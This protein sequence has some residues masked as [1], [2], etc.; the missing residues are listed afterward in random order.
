MARGQ[1]NKELLMMTVAISAAMGASAMAQAPDPT[2]VEEVVITGQRI[3]A[4]QSRATSIISAADIADRPLGAD[5]TQSL[6]KAPG[7]QISTGD[8]RGGSFSF[9]IYMRGLNKEQL[10]LTVDGVPSGDARFNGGSPPQR[11]IESSNI[12][13]ITVSQSSGDIGAP[14]RFALGGFIDFATDHPKPV[15]GGSVE[16]GY[17]SFDF[18]RGYMRFDTGEIAPGLAAYITYSQ[19]KNDI[20]TGRNSRK[21]KRDHVEFKMVQ[22]FADG[23]FLK[24][25]VSYND[26]Q[27][28]DFNI[29]TLPEFLSSPRSDRATDRLTGVPVTDLDFGGALGGE[30]TDVFGYLNGKLMIGETIEITANPYYQTLRGESYRYQ[31]RA[32]QLAGSNP[33]AVLS[34]N[35]NGGAVRPALTTLRSSNVLGGP[36][37]MRVTPRDRDRF[38]ITGEIKFSQLPLG[39]TVRVGG[40][41]E[42]GKSTEERRFYRLTDSLNSL[43]YNTSTINFVEYARTTKIETTMLYAQDSIELIAD[44]LQLDIGA[45]WF[46]IRYKAR[47]PL[48]Y[49]S[50]LDFSQDSGINPKLAFSWK[51]LPGVEVYGGYAQNFSGIP[52]DAFLG[53]TAVIAPGDLDPIRSENLDLG[54]RYVKGR[55]AFSAQAFSVHL[56][57]GIGI[58]P[59]DPTVVDVDEIIR[60]N[61]PTK[62]ANIQGLKNNGV[63]LTALAGAGPVDAFVSISFQDAKHEDPGAGSADRR[64]LAA[65]AVIGGAR[66]RDIPK[67]SAYG[68]ISYKPVQGLE[69]QGNVRY[70]GER[71]G[72]HIVAPTTFAEVG[73]ETI[74]SHT[75]FGMGVSYSLPVT[76]PLRGVKLQFNV[77]NMFDETYIG[78]VSSATANQPEFGLPG[79]TLDRYFIGAPRTYTVSLQARF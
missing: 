78:A 55:M 43:A 14:S 8:A 67:Q 77:D 39:Q 20:W 53:S 56:K 4:G 57:N 54:V 13:S 23:S 3:G 73:I 71:V 30:R 65:V 19:Q 68:E 31:D 33:Y 42:G 49:G 18:Y 24:A 44:V 69:V 5:I 79:R 6:V 26:Q 61:V 76:G 75:L 52:E 25:R 9:E 22:D 34:Y 27:D 16:A 58:V 74:P 7:V 47:S 21:S 66:V 70:V 10:G 32:R 45:T 37:D 59:R 11:F 62:A 35:A 60:G 28:N 41:V 1:R 64:N 63:E 15:M 38:G 12:G 50:V 2:A 72:G 17:G 40:W 46:D 51:A 29:V 48:E 36:V